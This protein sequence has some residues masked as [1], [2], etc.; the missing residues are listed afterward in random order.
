MSL[1][2]RVLVPTTLEI[3]STKMREKN[4]LGKNVLGG[5]KM[6][7]PPPLK[8]RVKV[9]VV[10]KCYFVVSLILFRLYQLSIRFVLIINADLVADLMKQHKLTLFWLKLTFCFILS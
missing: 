8:N 3:Q 6:P 2:H 5:A 9:F 4:W 7:P 10:K 1:R